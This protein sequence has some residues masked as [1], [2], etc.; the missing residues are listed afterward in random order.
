MRVNRKSLFCFLFTENVYGIKQTL[1]KNESNSFTEPGK[2]GKP[3]A[4]KITIK[5]ARTSAHRKVA[6]LRK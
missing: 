1:Y 5:R 4:S 3:L 6:L 2:K